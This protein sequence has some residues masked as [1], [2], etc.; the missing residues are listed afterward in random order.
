MSADAAPPSGP[1]RAGVHRLRVL[2]VRQVTRL[3]RRVTLAAPTLALLPLTPA[4]DVGLILVDAAGRSVRRRYTLTRVDARARTVTLDGVLHGSGP[5][6]AWFAE[7]AVGAEVEVFGPR[8]KIVLVDRAW[9]LFIGDESGV[10]AFLEL[11]AALPHRAVGVL[12]V[13]V[14]DAGE[15]QPIPAGAR[16]HA[17]WV[18]RN[19]APA[20][21]SDLLAAALAGVPLPPGGGQAYLLGES[22]A[23]VALRP[24]LAARGLSG[25]DVFLKGYWNATGRALG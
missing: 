25:S 7:V 5:G 14:A 22:R 21:G 9:H 2:D 11:A 4:Q 6:A 20:G 18:H 10:P 15:E 13:E 8:G 19:G 3:V 17:T 1:I 12:V 24:A 16:V 23:V